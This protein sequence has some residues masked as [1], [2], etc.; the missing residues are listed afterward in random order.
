LLCGGELFAAGAVAFAP[1]QGWRGE[2][3]QA[4]G[5]VGR[6]LILAASQPGLLVLA[7]G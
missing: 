1:A 7:G 2:L 3:L 4:G 5:Q 6:S